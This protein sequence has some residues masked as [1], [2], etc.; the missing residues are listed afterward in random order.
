MNET[1]QVWE[2]AGASVAFLLGGGGSLGEQVP[3]S[4]GKYQGRGWR[5]G[6]SNEQVCPLWGHT[7]M[8]N[9]VGG[10]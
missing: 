3:T 4:L 2:V 5:L 1:E 10:R 7:D 9:F 6:S 8:I